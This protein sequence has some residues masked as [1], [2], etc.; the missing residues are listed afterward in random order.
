MN[1]LPIFGP[2]IDKVT[3]L[4]PDPNARAQAK[5]QMEME[6]ITAANQALQGQ[7]EINKIEA[8]HKSLFVAGWRPFIGWVCGLSLL[9]G[10]LIQPFISTWVAAPN[11]NGDLLYPVLMG[12][13]GLGGLRSWEKSRGV[14]RES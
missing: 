5:E 1:W 14:A 2:I 8:A 3:R 7:L 9:Y 10:A 6:L 4:I 12:M 13:L 11:V